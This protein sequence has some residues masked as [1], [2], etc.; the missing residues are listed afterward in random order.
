MYM[1]LKHN[2]TL[3]PG[4]LTIHHIIFE[5]EEEKDEFGYPVSKLN[6]DGEPI[7]KEI[8]P[9]DLPYLKDE[10]LSIMMYYKENPSKFFKKKN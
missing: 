10:V 2:P 4:K 8:I 5:E 9:Y 3:K 6:A 7:I 1:I